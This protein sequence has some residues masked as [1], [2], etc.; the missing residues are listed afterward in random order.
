MK[1]NRFEEM[2]NKA[3]GFFMEDGEDHEQMYRRLKSLANAYK[4]LG[5]PHVDDAWIKRKYVNALLPFEP[6]DL[7]SLQG[8]H[9]Y[10]Q[11][12]SNEVMQEMQY[13]KVQAKIA[14]DSR[15]RA[16]GM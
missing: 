3:E 4:A 15:A 11:L 12:T 7:K 5:G 2:S 16:I 10:P 13:F 1:R 8:R 6:D 14:Q 9:D